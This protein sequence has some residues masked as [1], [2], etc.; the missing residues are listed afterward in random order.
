[1]QANAPTVRVLLS[2]PGCEA[3]RR[4][5]T[6]TGEGYRSFVSGIRL[7]IERLRDLTKNT[8]TVQC[9]LYSMTKGD[10]VDAA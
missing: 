1:M 8:G 10:E 7:S 9:H 4:P 5:S 3:A 2:D 6:E